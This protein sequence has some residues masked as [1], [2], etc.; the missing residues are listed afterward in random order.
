MRVHIGGD[1]AAYELLGDAGLVPRGGG[2]RGD[3]P[4]AARLD[5]EDDYPVFVLRAA[6]AVAADPDRSG[7]C[8]AARATASR[9]PPTRSPASGPRSATTTELATPRPR[10]QR[11]PG[12]LDRRPDDTVE[13]GRGD[14]A[15]PSSRP[16]SPASRGTSAASTW[17]A[18]TRTTALCSAPGL[19]PRRR[20]R[21][22]RVVRWPSTD[23]R[24]SRPWRWSSLYPRICRG[25]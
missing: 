16:R 24:G 18:P 11:R 4:R 15:R 8:W 25:H 1:H 14:G 2:P 22:R 7:S 20:P 23:L 19:S 21:T 3:Q 12:H 6:E 5:A 13:R 9:W 10:A 17:S